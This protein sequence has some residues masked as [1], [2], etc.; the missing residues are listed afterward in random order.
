MVTR[1]DY[2]RKK[3]AL[4]DELFDAVS[5]PVFAFV[6]TFVENNGWNFQQCGG[7]CVNTQSSLVN[8]V[9][10]GTMAGGAYFTLLN[11]RQVPGY[12]PTNALYPPGGGNPNLIRRGF[13]SDTTNI[14]PFTF[15]SVWGTEVGRTVAGI[16]GVA[17]AV[18][19]G[20][21]DCGERGTAR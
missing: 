19:G 7:A 9:G 16:S 5:V 2:E 14:S 13:S 4:I 1:E 21:G 12:I 17:G 3:R 11:A 15:N 10:S 6:T 8:T 18:R 20:A